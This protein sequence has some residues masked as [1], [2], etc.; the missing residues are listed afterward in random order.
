MWS[1]AVYDLRLTTEQFFKLSL[2]QFNALV[3]RHHQFQM[4]DDMRAGQLCSLVAGMFGK[5][6]DGSSFNPGDFFPSLR[7]LPQFQQK[8]MSGEDMLMFL[9]AAF[10]ATPKVQN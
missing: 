1:I 9:K 3:E 8:E 10:P 5:K 4:Q 2:R 6:K 7:E